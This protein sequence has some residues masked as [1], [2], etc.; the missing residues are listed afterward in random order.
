MR[1][2]VNHAF[3]RNRAGKQRVLRLGPD[4]AKHRRP[5]EKAANELA[6]HWRLANPCRRLTHE[7]TDQEQQSEL[8]DKDRFG[9][10]RRAAILRPSGRGDG[11]RG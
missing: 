1:D 10:A 7:P 6:H 8:G 4:E 2:G 5:E 3:L 9:A 11:G